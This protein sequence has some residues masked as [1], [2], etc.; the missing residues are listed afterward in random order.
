MS[1]PFVPV[2]P[3]TA[4]R[5]GRP[6]V[7]AVDGRD[8]A[9]FNV[10]DRFYAIDNTCPHQGAPLAEGWIEGTTITCPWHAWCFKLTDGMMTLGTFA[11]VDTFEVKV[12]GETLYVDP[13]PRPRPPDT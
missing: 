2:G 13:R 6:H 5:P 9:V 10:G 4:V 7:F 12:E 3:A 11:S 8:V 1:D